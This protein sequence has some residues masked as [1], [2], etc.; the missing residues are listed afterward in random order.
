MGG[1]LDAGY[2]LEPI[3]YLRV[4]RYGRFSS[5]LGM[6]LGREANFEQYVLHYIAAK[7]ALKT[8]GTFGLRLEFLIF[9]GLAKQDIIKTPLRRRQ[10]AWDTHFTA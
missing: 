6:K 4:Q 7:F 8:E 5:G 9:I 2:I 1:Q 3:L 10:G